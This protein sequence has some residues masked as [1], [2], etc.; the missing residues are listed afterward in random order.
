MAKYTPLQLT[1]ARSTPTCIYWIFLILFI[2]YINGTLQKG[3]LM[4]EKRTSIGGLLVGATIGLLIGAGIALLAAP[5]SGI[6]TRSLIRE[7]ST[8][9][10]DKA[11]G[12][13]METRRR[14][15]EKLVQMRNQA[16]RLLRRS[17][18]EALLEPL[19]T[20]ESFYEN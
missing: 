15:E 2:Q 20:P 17:E 16:N 7:K 1:Y 10:R 11:S 3:L 8:Q 5:Q 4:E 14:A 18:N 13:I 12:S 9:A 6:Q 19:E